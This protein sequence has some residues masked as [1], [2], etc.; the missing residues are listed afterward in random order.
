MSRTIASIAVVL[1]LLGCCIPEHAIAQQTPADSSGRFFD[2]SV[3]LGISVHST[4]SLSNYIN[5]LTQPTIDQK[6]DQFNSAPEFSIVPELQVANEWSV[7]LEYSLLVKSYSIDSRTSYPHTDISYQV[8]MPSVLVHYLVFG[9]GFRLKFGG[10]IGYHFMK[11]EQSFPALGVDET[12]RTNGPG[13]KLD[14]VGNTKFDESFYGSIGLDLRWD[15]LGT[16]SRGSAAS[17]A[18]RS[19]P[20]LPSMTFFNAGVKLGVTFQLL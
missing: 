20:D 17:Q 13:F 6:V 5:A 12:F 3:V 11:F 7:G 10:G 16:L 15:F 8:Q 2:I 1:V 9:Q 14:A 18:A 4:P 19:G